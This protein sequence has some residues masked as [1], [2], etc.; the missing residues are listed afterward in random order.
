MKFGRFL[1]APQEIRGYGAPMVQ[2]FAVQAV[3][4]LSDEQERRL[5]LSNAVRS[6][7]DNKGRS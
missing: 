3:K 1:Q 4:G 5:D 7:R 6:G 2:G